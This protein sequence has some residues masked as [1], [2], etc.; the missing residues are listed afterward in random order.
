MKKIIYSFIL[1]FTIGFISCKDYLQET[2]PNGISSD[3]YWS[4]L[5]E[6]Q[7]ALT[8]VYGAML[9]TYVHNIPAQ[10]VR[11]DLAFPTA[12]TR[13]VGF[14][15]PFY[16]QQFN[17]SSRDIQFEWDA[18]YQVIFRAN[19]VIEGLE[20]LKNITDQARWTQQMAEARFFRGLAHFY[21]HADYNNG[22]IIIR[23][24]VP[25]SL[26]DHNKGVSTSAEVITFFREDLKFAYDNLPAQYA[27]SKD[28]G[29]ATKGAAATILGTSLLYEK[30]YDKAAVYFNDVITNPAYGYEIVQNLDLMFTM[31]GE[32]NKESILEINYSL[33]YQLEDSQWDEESFN[34]RMARYT[35]PGNLGGGAS[36]T[37]YFTPSAWITNAYATEAMD[38]KD[39]RNFV[40]DGTPTGKKLRSV[41]LRASSMVALVQDLD[42]KYYLA[43]NAANIN[44]FA[45]LAFSHFKKYTN[46][47]IVSHEDLTGLTGWKS[48]KNV[49]I[50]RLAEVYLMQAECLIK[51]GKISEALKLMNT[52]RK[53]WGLKL[54]GPTDGSNHDF[55][56]IAYTQTTLMNQLMYVDKPLELSTEGHAMRYIDMR[57]W[58]ITKQRFDELSK[59]D[60]YATNYTYKVTATGANAIRQ[61]ALLVAGKTPNATASP[62]IIEYDITTQNY[63][64]AV[65]AY[66]PIPLSEILNNPAVK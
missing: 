8:G 45:N 14:G 52:I 26:A 29:R 7:S 3:I 5:D 31:A 12:R 37:D 23:N 61:K 21:L 33:D 57:R 15:L 54:L 9:N 13:P 46:H 36:A 2:N 55:D 17:N 44:A 28:L 16:Y 66:F 34:T 63:Q 35:A 24:K 47:D 25:K 4:T 51:T 27:N 53:R 64:D 42:T 56:G 43:A 58:G 48:G 49:T 39:T 38:T 32:F 60:F 10:S 18:C 59:K 11:S 6:T 40:S 62:A 19:Q 30:E 1:I 50:N 41:P 65:H 20:N 22:Q